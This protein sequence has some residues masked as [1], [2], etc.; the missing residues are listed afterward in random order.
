MAENTA[1]KSDTKT[2]AKSV[3]QISIAPEA[4]AILKRRALADDRPVSYEVRRALRSY[5]VSV[6]EPDPWA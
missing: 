6:G 4:Y 3:T 2:P 5:F 1:T